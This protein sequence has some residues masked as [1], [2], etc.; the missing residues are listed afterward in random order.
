MSRDKKIDYVEFHSTD[1]AAT[2]HFYSR[3]FGWKFVDYGPDYT[4]FDDGRIAGGF[5]KGQGSP[6]AGPLVV[7]FVDDLQA[8]E[9]L[10]KETGGKITKEIFSFPGGSRFEFTDPTGNKLAA[11]HE[12]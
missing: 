7:I 11:W 10:V 3:V 5:R 2:K 12:G 9:S 8:T 6:G 1:L 4:S